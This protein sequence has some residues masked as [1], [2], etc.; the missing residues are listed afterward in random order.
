VDA[1]LLDF[2]DRRAEV[3]QVESK[4]DVEIGALLRLRIVDNV[5][6][7]MALPFF[8]HI[9]SLRERRRVARDDDDRVVLIVEGSRPCWPSGS[10]SHTR[11]PEAGWRRRIEDEPVLAGILSIQSSCA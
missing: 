7:G 9:A 3:R 4:V 5:T 8:F 10:C 6:G 2:R 11:S 1:F